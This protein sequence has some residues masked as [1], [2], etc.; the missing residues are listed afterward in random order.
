M[1]TLRIRY[2]GPCPKIPKYTSLHLHGKPK[3]PQMKALTERYR[4]I[5]DGD[6]V[7]HG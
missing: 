6:E 2:F 4:R 7:L 1:K 5:L 3:H